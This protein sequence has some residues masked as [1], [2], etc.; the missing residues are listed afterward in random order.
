M[1]GVSKKIGPAY[2]GSTALTNSKVSV[3]QGS[4]ELI[5]AQGW[6][7]MMA[8]LSIGPLNFYLPNSITRQFIPLQ[9]HK[10]TSE[11]MSHS[12]ISSGDADSPGDTHYSHNT[13]SFNYTVNNIG[14]TDERSE[15]LAWLSPLESRIRHQ[16]LRT[17]RADNIGEWLLQ[18]NEFQRWC[19]DAEQDRS[20]H[21]TLFCDGDPGVGKTYF[22]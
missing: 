20:E 5:G 10:L 6:D 17:L 18:T 1:L 13:H 4:N 16:G 8:P 14:A 12:R 3:T 2:P 19:N 11:K 15:I 7:I 21:A 22:R 9:H